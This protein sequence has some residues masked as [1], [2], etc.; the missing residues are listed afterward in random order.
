MWTKLKSYF[1]NVNQILPKTV[2]IRLQCYWS[3]FWRIRKM[4]FHPNDFNLWSSK[5]PTILWIRRVERGTQ[6][7]GLGYKLQFSAH[8]HLTDMA[9]GVAMP[10]W[11]IITRLDFHFQSFRWVREAT[12]NK[13]GWFTILCVFPPSLSHPLETPGWL[14]FWP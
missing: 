4:G 13:R 1:Q 14:I 10:S 11:N 2:K 8:P 3:L 7:S 9:F 5:F 6:I 12:K